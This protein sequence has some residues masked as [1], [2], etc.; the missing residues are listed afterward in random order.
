MNKKALIALALLILLPVLLIWHKKQQG[1]SMM[2]MGFGT[3]YA[4]S[5]HPFNK[6]DYPVR[7]HNIYGV[8]GVDNRADVILP[9]KQGSLMLHIPRDAIRYVKKRSDSETC[10]PIKI[11]LIYIW[12]D[13]KLLRNAKIDS[14]AH[15]AGVPSDKHIEVTLSGLQYSYPPPDPSKPTKYAEDRRYVPAHRH[16][17]LPLW[18]YPQLKYDN[19]TKSK[20]GFGV[21]NTIDPDTNHPYLVSCSLKVK[22]IGSGET[23][24]DY[25]PEEWVVADMKQ[26]HELGSADCDGFK[27][28]YV[29]ETDGIFAE[30]RLVPEAVPEID[31]IYQSIDAVIQAYVKPPSPNDPAP[32]QEREPIKQTPVSDQ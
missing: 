8:Y 15:D 28:I 12:H 21:A 13:G 9:I 19:F 16:T 30:L 29:T 1:I 4:N 25:H 6:P 2:T 7:C 24:Y 23:P 14:E 31:K 3:Q 20:H 26:T 18:Y 17:F 27:K 11:K 5:P 10:I 32:A 22:P